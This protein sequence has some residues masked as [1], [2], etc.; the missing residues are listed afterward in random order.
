MDSIG[1]LLNQELETMRREMRVMRERI[2]ELEKCRGGQLVYSVKECAEVMGIPE[3]SVRE[4]I[5]SGRLKA[6]HL[7]GGK[8]RYMVYRMDIEEFILRRRAEG[9]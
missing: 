1:Q 8:Q 7:E 2:T 5:R 6:F 9:R 4:L 3:Y